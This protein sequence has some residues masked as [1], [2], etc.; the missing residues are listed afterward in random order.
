[1]FYGKY[2][3]SVNCGKSRKYDISVDR[4]YR[5]VVFHV[6]GGDKSFIKYHNSKILDA[7]IAFIV[8]PKRFDDPLLV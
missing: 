2:D 3:I 8:T 1:M 5:N 6:V 7:S 4:F